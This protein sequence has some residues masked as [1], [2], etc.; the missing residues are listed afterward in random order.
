MV[1]VSR[2]QSQKARILSFQIADCTCSGLEPTKGVQ[3]LLHHSGW[4]FAW[5]IVKTAL[6][7]EIGLGRNEYRQSNSLVL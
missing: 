7:F 6:L 2:N 4:A 5:F 1:R 3:A